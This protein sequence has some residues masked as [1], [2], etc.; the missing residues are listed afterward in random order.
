MRRCRSLTT[1]ATETPW[2]QGI[3]G[4]PRYT[5]LEDRDSRTVSTREDYYAVI[6]WFTDRNEHSGNCVGHW[7]MEDPYCIPRY[8]RL[9]R[10]VCGATVFDLFDVDERT[11]T[12]LRV[13]APSA[14]ILDDTMDDSLR[15]GVLVA[16]VRMSSTTGILVKDMYGKE[17]LTLASH[18]FPEATV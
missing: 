17:L 3:L 4:N 6:C 18:G 15:P 5:T 7:H 14:K 11:E 8:Y 16:S 12:A 13:R 9:A 1:N 10:K 2:S